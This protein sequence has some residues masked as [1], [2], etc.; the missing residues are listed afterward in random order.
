MVS[1]LLSSFLQS[2]KYSLLD[3]ETHHVIDALNYT[4]EVQMKYYSHI[5]MVASPTCTSLSYLLWQRLPGR[6]N[7][8][9]KQ[10]GD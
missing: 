5:N 4:L 3:T 9:E 8:A 2:T 1:L 6:T 10:D 7:P